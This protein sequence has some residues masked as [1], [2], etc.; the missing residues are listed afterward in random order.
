MTHLTREE[1][2]TIIRASDADNHWVITTAS[3]KLIQ[4]FTR[5]GPTAISHPGTA[6]G[7][8]LGTLGY[9]V[10]QLSRTRGRVG[11]ASQS[12]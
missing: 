6:P 11:S 4:K 1:R 8:I 7:T 3:P 5:V 12:A 2:E 10:P 9:M